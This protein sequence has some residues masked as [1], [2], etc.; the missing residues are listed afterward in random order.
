M[1]AAHG[2]A[3]RNI[4][5][6]PV[7]PLRSGLQVPFCPQQC[8]RGAAG[9][10]G[11][12]PRVWA[13]ARGVTRRKPP[14]PGPFWGCFPQERSQGASRGARGYFARRCLGGRSFPG[15]RGGL[16][17][18]ARGDCAVR[19]KMRRTGRADPS[20]RRDK[21]KKRELCCKRKAVPW[22]AFSATVGRANEARCLATPR[23]L[24]GARRNNGRNLR[25][26]WAR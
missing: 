6:H 16:G 25:A 26:Q 17:T 10:L 21:K 4:L 9:T 23:A 24:L 8:Y 2:A 12:F 13:P 7:T 14:L 1:R 3:V 15:S 19:A 5:R 18:P 20:R 11:A 22:S